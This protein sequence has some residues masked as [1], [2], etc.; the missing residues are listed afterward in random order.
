MS[1]IVGSQHECAY[2]GW[3]GDTR[4]HVPALSMYWLA[5]ANRRQK[6]SFKRNKWIP[7]CKE[8]N[9]SLGNSYLLTI[10]DRA[11]HLIDRYEEKYRKLLNQPVW[12]EE[13]LER[14]GPSMKQFIQSK[15]VERQILMDR[16][17]HLGTISR[18]GPLTVGDYWDE[19]G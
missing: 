2:C 9:T 1:T 7:A 12:G 16:L 6:A 18:F 8:C 11:N 3:S 17:A 10:Q 13:E 4:D 15:A 5:G 19:V 14:M